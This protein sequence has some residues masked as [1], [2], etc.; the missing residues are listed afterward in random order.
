MFEGD[1]IMNRSSVRYGRTEKPGSYCVPR[2]DQTCAVRARCARTD[3][4]STTVIFD[5]HAY[6][7]NVGIRAEADVIRREPWSVPQQR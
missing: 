3:Q 2:T 5:G 1:R 7:V 4:L 6:M